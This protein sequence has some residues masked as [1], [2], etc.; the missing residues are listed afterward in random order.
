MRTA[1]ANQY[2][3]VGLDTYEPTASR[4]TSS[5]STKSDIQS[6]P[7]AGIQTSEL[8][9]PSFVHV[10][11]WYTAVAARRAGRLNAAHVSQQEYNLLLDERQKL[12]DKLFDGTINK[13]EQRRLAYVRWSLDTIDDAR[14]GIQLDMMEDLAKVYE[15][16]AS[17]IQSLQDQLRPYNTKRRK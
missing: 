8:K 15:K 12:L 17:D 9:I 4:G 16:F 1:A 14:S 7:K 10:K 2:E 5:G 11:D 13:S 6:Q 3:I